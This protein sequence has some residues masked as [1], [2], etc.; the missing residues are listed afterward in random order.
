MFMDRTKI[1]VVVVTWNNEGDIVECLDSLKTQSE[2]DFKVI[3]VDNASTDNTASLVKAN[4][5]DFVHLIE[6]NENIFLSPGNNTGM[7]FALE[8]YDPEFILVLNPDTKVEANLLSEL[9]KPMSDSKVGAVGPKVKFY[10]NKNEG[11]IN[12]AGLIF[13]GFN[14]AYD[15]GFEV[16]DKGQYNEQKEVFGVTGACILYRVAML[17][18]IGLY[19]EKIKLYMDEVEMFIRAGKAG[20]KVVYNPSTTLLHKYM[21][22][23]DQH[24]LER[25]NNLKKKAWLWIALRHYSFKS[26]LIM[27]KNFLSN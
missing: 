14:Q 20:W 4:Y 16:E 17:K 18:E 19:W 24:K 26:K 25:I 13:D 11:L 9:Q 12:S 8:N 1:A 22:S 7:K 15:I 5:S 6:L 21:K 3:V 10:K 2:K 23:T 27:I